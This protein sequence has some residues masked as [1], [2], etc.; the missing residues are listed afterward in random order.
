MTKVFL[1]DGELYMETQKKK[2]STYI[3]WSADYKSKYE[4]TQFLYIQQ[5]VGLSMLT[6]KI[7]SKILDRYLKD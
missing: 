2:K 3:V 5:Y 4:L 7:V 1:L 6:S